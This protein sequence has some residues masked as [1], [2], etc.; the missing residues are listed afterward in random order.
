MSK[1]EKQFNGFI[2]P[3]SNYFRMPNEWINICAEI[4][5]LA[6]LKVVQYVLRH[7]WGFREYDGKPKPITIDEFMHGRISKGER[8]DKGTGLSKQS[9]VEGVKN[10][11][12][13]GY[14]ICE[15]DDSDRGR[16]SKSYALNMAATETDVKNLDIKNRCQESRHRRS[17]KLTPDVGNLDINGQE[18]RHR[19]E[20]DTSER[21]F[22]K[23][24]SERKGGKSSK[25]ATTNKNVSPSPQ[26]N[27]SSSSGRKSFSPEVVIVLDCWDEIRGSKVPRSDKQKKAAKEL[28]E[29]DATK[30]QIKDVEQFCLQ[31]NPEWYAVHGIDLQSISNNWS[32]WQTAQEHKGKAVKTSSK[33]TK[34]A[35]SSY[36]D[37]DFIDDT[38]Y[39]TRRVE[40]RHGT[41]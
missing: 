4:K 5:S 17:R 30:E 38:F 16:I 33:T 28:A 19:S 29:V 12:D 36:D 7:T 27:Q 22:E 39:P 31:D 37:D 1:E 2:P 26:K 24:T 11:I 20:K 34:H 13:H 41:H 3:A 23:N 18:S 6:E 40:A 32:K 8:M 35:V 25:P 15:I 10:A 21:H 9:V 14:L